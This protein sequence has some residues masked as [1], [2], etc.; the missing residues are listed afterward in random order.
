MTYE[1]TYHLHQGSQ[2]GAGVEGVVGPGPASGVRGVG[3]SAFHVT[4]RRPYP[5]KNVVAQ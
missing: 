4:W 5:R 3:I 1:I 2:E